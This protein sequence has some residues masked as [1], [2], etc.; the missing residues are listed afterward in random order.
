MGKAEPMERGKTPNG[1][2]VINIKRK[3]MVQLGKGDGSASLGWDGVHLGEREGEEKQRNGKEDKCEG[4]CNQ[5]GVNGW[6]PRLQTI[7][8]EESTVGT[9]RGHD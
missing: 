8:S 1:G 7:H 3:E 6:F 5:W 4:D 2:D 9:A